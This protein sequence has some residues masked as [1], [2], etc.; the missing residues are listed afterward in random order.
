MSCVFQSVVKTGRLLISHEAPVTGGFAAEISTTVQVSTFI[1]FLLD[2]VC[3]SVFSTVCDDVLLGFVA[4][5]NRRWSSKVLVL[6]GFN[7]FVNKSP[8]L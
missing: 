7:S 5:R 3:L 4:P 8:S 6:I 1:C 2:I